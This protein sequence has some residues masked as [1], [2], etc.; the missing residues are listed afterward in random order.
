MNI[1]RASIERPIAII[2]SVLMVLMFGLVALNTIP[3]QLTPDIRKPVLSVRTN[4]P[5][6]AP[7]EVEREI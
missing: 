7:V 5:G 4:W 2:A 3:I 6:A 1:I